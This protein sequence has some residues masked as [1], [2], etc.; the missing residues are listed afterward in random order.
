[1]IGTGIRKEPGRKTNPYP[2]KN[3]KGKS[4]K[5]VASRA[6]KGSDG[7]GGAETAKVA[8]SAGKGMPPGVGVGRTT[9]KPYQGKNSQGQSHK[10]VID[11]WCSGKRKSYRA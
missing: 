6:D 9:A 8:K 11:E 2:A 5:T 3:A 10:T 1:M 4:Y 7:G